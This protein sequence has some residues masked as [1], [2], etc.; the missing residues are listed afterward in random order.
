MRRRYFFSGTTSTGPL[1]PTHFDTPTGNERLPATLSDLR[2]SHTRGMFGTEVVL[3]LAALKICW[4]TRVYMLRGN[5]ESRRITTWFNFKV[6]PCRPSHGSHW[7]PWAGASGI[8]CFMQ[9]ECEYKYDAEVHECFCE[10][11]FMSRSPRATLAPRLGSPRCHICTG[12][13]RDYAHPRCHIAIGT[14]PTDRPGR[15]MLCR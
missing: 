15:S 9:T 6:S 10:A 7:V 3:L 14:R 13:H 12:T 8:G 1:P 4:P 2:G 11:S 5:H